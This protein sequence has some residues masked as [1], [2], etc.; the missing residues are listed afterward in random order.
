[1]KGEKDG[2]LR[3]LE[4]FHAFVKKIGS[5]SPIIFNVLSFE[6]VS[7]LLFSVL[8]TQGNSPTP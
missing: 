1:M 6:M 5:V 4:N 8:P 2:V 7:P 3:V